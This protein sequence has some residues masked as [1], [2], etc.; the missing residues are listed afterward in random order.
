MKYPKKSQIKED[1]DFN[2]SEKPVL[3]FSSPEAQKVL[4]VAK[5]GMKDPM[6]G[7]D[8]KILKYMEAGL[9]YL[10]LILKVVEGFRDS[11][12]AFKIQQPAPAAAQIE[13]NIAP[14]GWN[15]M[16]AMDRLKYKYTMA[17]WYQAGELY[18][19]RKALGSINPQVNINQQP[20]PITAREARSLSELQKKYPEPPLIKDDSPHD[21]HAESAEETERNPKASAALHDDKKED[22]KMET[23]INSLNEDNM[24]YLTIAFDY[25]NKMPEKEFQTMIKDLPS[26]QGKFEQY[27]FFIPVQLKA[28]ISNTS[29]EDF[30]NLISEK[31][32][33]KYDLLK[34]ARKTNDL[35]ELF[36]NIRESIKK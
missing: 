35:L 23:L 12:Q 27:K 19:Q 2:P 13:Q 4:S 25:I 36:R 6:T 17:E 7:E 26:L 30:E 3:D 16:T 28:M 15:S 24:K 9:K 33:E 22:V 11:A 18:E 21:D 34:K 1:E 10:P 14:E 8:D 32:K 20:P 29:P 5:E 31:C